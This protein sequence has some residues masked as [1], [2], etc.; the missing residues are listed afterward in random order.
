MT[1]DER[2]F[3]DATI[4]KDIALH[5]YY[6]AVAEV[7]TDNA[8]SL[9]TRQRTAKAMHAACLEFDKARRRITDPHISKI[10]LEESND[11]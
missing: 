10:K 3:I 1:P 4:L 9:W 8:A 6:R 5:H 7:T 2:E 11:T